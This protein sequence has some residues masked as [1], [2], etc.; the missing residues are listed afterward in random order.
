MGSKSIEKKH[1]WYS[2]TT[3]NSSNIDHIVCKLHWLNMWITM[4]FSLQW[5]FLFDNVYTNRRLAKRFIDKK[6]RI[7]AVSISFVC[8]FVVDF[9]CLFFFGF[10]LCCAL[11]NSNFWCVLF[12]KIECEC[13]KW[14][15]KIEKKA[16]DFFGWQMNWIDK[17]NNKI[18]LLCVGLK[19]I[20]LDET[21]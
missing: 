1:Y 8:L 11:R 21:Q 20:A 5:Y 7:I 9:V 15:T 14:S 4:H 16:N 2:C 3:S 18:S 6:R 12:V 10:F 13:A 17:N 19:W